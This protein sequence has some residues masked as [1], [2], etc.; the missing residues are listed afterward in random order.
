MAKLHSKEPS[1]SRNC[2]SF[3]IAL[4]R[5]IAWTVVNGC[6]EIGVTLPSTLMAGGNSEVMNRSEPRLFTMSCKSSWMYLVAA[7]RSSM[8]CPSC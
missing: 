8:A 5:P 2:F 4:T 1:N 7:S 3:M 6:C